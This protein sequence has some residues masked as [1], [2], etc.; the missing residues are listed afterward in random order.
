MYFS[1]YTWSC[2]TFSVSRCKELAKTAFLLWK[3]KEIYLFFPSSLLGA[4]WSSSCSS[5]LI[6]LLKFYSFTLP[7]DNFS[8]FNLEDE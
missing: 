6:I 2:G 5:V 8:H 1:K 7:N 3:D 4:E